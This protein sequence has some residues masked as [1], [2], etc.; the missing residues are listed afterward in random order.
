MKRDID[1]F[2]TVEGDRWEVLVE[3][4][5]KTDHFI[6]LLQKSGENGVLTLKQFI[7]FEVYQDF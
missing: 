3:E 5:L 7:S 1:R 4:G 2:T 6:A